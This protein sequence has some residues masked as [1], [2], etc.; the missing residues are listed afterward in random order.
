MRRLMLS[1]LLLMSAALAMRGGEPADTCGCESAGKAYWVKQLFRNGFHINDSTVCYPRFPRFALKVYNWGDRTFNRYDPAYVVGTGKNWKLT[2]KTQNWIES[3]NMLFPESR[4]LAMHSSVY[5]DAGV[6]LSF[7]AVSLG[8]TWNMNKLLNQPSSRKTFDFSFTTSRFSI[9]INQLSSS[10]GMIITNFGDYNDGRRLRYHF[11]DVDFQS[12]TAQ[13]YWFFNNYRYSQAAAYS[14][15]RYQLRSAGS[16]L[17]GFQYNEQKLSM[18]FSRLPADMLPYLPLESPAYDS[19]YRSYNLMGGYAF[20]W[21][22]YPRR[23]LVNIFATGSVGY[24]EV[25]GDRGEERHSIKSLLSNTVQTNIAG[26]YNHRAL[27]VALTMNFYGIFN[28]NS[29]YTHFDAYGRLTGVA[30]V[31]F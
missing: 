10:G 3:T 13:A 19:H 22:L 21:V 15:S 4:E 12:T 11:D 31:R 8:W 23:W 6:S 5:S 14:W 16:A 25:L 26:V 1:A 17:A 2:A 27:F 24:R 29:R 7:M 9:A 30:G 20:N 18:D 28:Y